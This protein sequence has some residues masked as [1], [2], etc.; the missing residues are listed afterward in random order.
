[1]KQHIQ[2]HPEDVARFF[3]DW[4]LKLI[5]PGKA[6]HW[7][8]SGGS[9]P[10][11]LFALLAHEYAGRFPWPDIHFW[12]GDERCVPPDHADSNY[13]MTAELLLRQVPIPSQNIHRVRG[14]NPPKEEAARYAREI[15]QFVPSYQKWPVFD[16]VMLGMGADGHTASIFPHEMNLLQSKRICEV[17][18][19]PSSGQKRITLT[20][21]VLNQA[22]KKAFLVTGADKTAKV[23][24]IFTGQEIARSYPASHV[25]GAEW[26]LDQAAVGSR[27]A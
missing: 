13:R 23:N 6:F 9:T 7:A 11:L 25:Q 2:A 19:H 12:W 10:R 16:L 3:A 27:S 26:F 21:K 17:A 8:L 20:G 14:E 5:Q 24:E 15:A 22:S 4:T 1:M 18:T